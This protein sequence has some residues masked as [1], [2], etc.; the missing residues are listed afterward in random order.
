VPEMLDRASMSEPF[1]DA[2]PASTIGNIRFRRHSSVRLQH[3]A[4][5]LSGRLQTQHL[6]PKKPRLH[7]YDSDILMPAPQA[8]RLSILIRIRHLLF[9][10]FLARMCMQSIV[11]TSGLSHGV[12]KGSLLLIFVSYL[13]ETRILG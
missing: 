8:F 3:S 10:A 7:K 5:H 1:R 4:V 2:T 13:L 12:R 11:R 6:L 9:V